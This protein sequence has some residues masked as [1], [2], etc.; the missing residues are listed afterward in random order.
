MNSGTEAMSLVFLLIISAVPTPQFGW[1][2]QLTW[3]H[4][5]CGPCAKSAASTKLPI[6]EI[7]NQSRVGSVIPT[8]FFTSCAKWLKV[9]RWRIRRSS[10][11][12]S[13]R[14]VNDTGWNAMNAI[15]PGL[16]RAN[17][18]IG[19]TSSL[20]TLFTNVV[21]STISMPASCMF[22]IALILTSNRLPILRCWFGSLP[23]PSNCRYA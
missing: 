17:W 11:I 8:C 9:Y 5:A 22:S 15:R 18:M 7:G 20:L 21:T 1:Q 16:S 13:S 10:V 23:I 4:C 6:T 2:P 14:P 3:P 19:P 12:S